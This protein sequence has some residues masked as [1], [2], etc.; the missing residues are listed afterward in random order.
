MVQT[1]SWCLLLPN[2]EL[3]CRSLGSKTVRNGPFTASVAQ[4]I[5]PSTDGFS[6]LCFPSQHARALPYKGSDRLGNHQPYA[7]YK[8]FA[9]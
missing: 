6:L 4:A 2:Y 1:R 5:N 8:P 9:R 7:S 3:T